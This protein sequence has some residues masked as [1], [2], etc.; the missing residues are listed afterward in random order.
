M[1]PAKKKT[2][3]AHEAAEVLAHTQEKKKPAAKK[4]SKP[5]KEKTAPSP[6]PRAKKEIDFVIDQLALLLSSG[7]DVVAALEAV[8]S[9]LKGA[10]M[11][12]LLMQMRDDIQDGSSLTEALRK[13]KLFKDHVITLIDVGEQSGRLGEN[14]IIVL[15]QQE[16]ERAFK[17]R[18]RSAMMYP[19]LVLSL[20]SIIG[21]GLT[22]F[23]LPKITNLFVS[24]DVDLPWITRVLMWIGMVVKAYGHWLIPTIVASIITTVYVLF[25]SRKTKFMGQWIILHTPLLKKLIQEVELARFGFILGTLLGAGLPILQALKSLSEATLVR[26]YGRLYA[27]LEMQI[28]RGQSFSDAFAENK[29]KSSFLIPGAVQQLIVTGERTGKL[30]SILVQIGQRYEERT[31]VSAKNISV[32]LEPLLLLFV[33]LIVAGLAIGIILPIY[34]LV[35]S[36]G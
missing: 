16:K 26:Q 22:W 23:I 28:G 3:N 2:T 31:E 35:G 33:S 19:V 6:A 14:L 5:K 20:A 4:V 27:D 30:S 36:V 11:K 25:L 29:K 15:Q 24:L 8:H 1:P 7:M 9:E 34:T 18:L 32:V 21:L 13:T 10:S 12:A 17:D